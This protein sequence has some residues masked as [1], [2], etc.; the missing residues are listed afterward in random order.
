MAEILVADDDGH[1]R[2]VVRFALTRAGHTVIEAE[3]G[4]VALERFAARPIDVVVLDILMPELDG[5]E[6]CRTLRS[7]PPPKGLVPILFLSSRDDELDRVLGL[8]MGADDYVTKPFS[9]REL[10]ARVKAMLRRV[11]AAAPAAT[12]PA[13][14]L[15][16]GPLALDPQRHRVF[17]DGTELVLTLTEFNLLAA[18]LGM[19]GKVYTRDDLVDRVWGPGHA[20]TDRTIDSHI[21]RIRRKFADLSADPIDT[22]YG[23]GYRL[24]EDL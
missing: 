2:E 21:R 24:R 20:I 11:A 12:T 22:V 8:E 5:L 18:L 9:P 17:W 4:R 14:V 16:K 7:L 13:A 15:R 10:V 19:P 3:D 1:I 6:V 23:L